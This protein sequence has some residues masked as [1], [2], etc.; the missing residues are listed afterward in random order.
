M[1]RLKTIITHSLLAFVLISIGFALGKH[2]VSSIKLDKEHSSSLKEEKHIA[3]Y[4]LHATFRCVT[5]NTIE[6]MTRTLLNDSY[7]K[8]L[9]FD[10]SATLTIGSIN[11]AIFCNATRRSSR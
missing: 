11:N 8:E 4:Y 2:S 7:R 9:A 3:V 10:T 5:C 6:K 1:I